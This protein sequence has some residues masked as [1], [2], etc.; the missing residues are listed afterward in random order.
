MKYRW[1]R[2]RLEE[3]K[4]EGRLCKGLKVEGEELMVMKQVNGVKVM[5]GRE[6]VEV[7]EMRKCG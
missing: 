5:G 3:R 6:R 4:G 2:K 1:E 7:S